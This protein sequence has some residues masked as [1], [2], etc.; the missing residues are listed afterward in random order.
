MSICTRIV[1]GRGLVQLTSRPQPAGQCERLIHSSD[2]QVRH[3]FYI[4]DS[5]FLSKRI[6]PCVSALLSLQSAKAKPAAPANPAGGGTGVARC[7]I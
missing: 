1:Q 2:I 5:D 6:F 3:F 7:G 4:S